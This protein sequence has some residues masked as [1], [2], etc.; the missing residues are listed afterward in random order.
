M[1]YLNMIPGDS[2]DSLQVDTEG[3]DEG[4]ESERV[5][6]VQLHFNENV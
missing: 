3:E 5:S 1:H 6:A 4:E 2:R